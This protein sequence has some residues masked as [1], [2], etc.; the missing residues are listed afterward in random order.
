MSY[1]IAYEH[2]DIIAALASLAGAGAS[3]AGP[4]PAATVH[5]LQIHG[6]EDGTIAYT[7]DNI[8]GSAYPGA[9]E[10]VERWAAYNGCEATGV[11]VARFDLEA[12]IAGYDSTAVRYATGCRLGGSGELWTIDSGSH[13]PSLSS[14]FSENVINWLMAHPKVRDSSA[15]GSD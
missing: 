15:N 10:T 7:G 2:P 1:R 6:T 8:N 14:S 13:I 5:V 3:E 12:E 11:E 9:V 4:A